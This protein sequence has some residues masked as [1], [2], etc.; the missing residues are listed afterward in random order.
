[1]RIRTLLLAKAIPSAIAFALI[2]SGLL[3]QGIAQPQTPPQQQRTRR[4][5]R[6]H[7]PKIEVTSPDGKLKFILLPN[8]ERLTFTLTMGAATV[9]EPSPIAMTLDGYDL[10]SGVVFGDTQ[11]YQTDETYPWYG[12]H[13][14]AVDQSNGAKIALV[15]DLSLTQYVLEVRAFNEGVAFRHVIPGEENRTRVPDEY[16]CFLIPDGSTVWYGGLADGHYETEYAS[17]PI[18]D[19]QPGEWAGPPLTLRLPHEAGYASI[20]EANLVNYSGMGLESDGHR[21]WVIGL[22][23]RQPLNWPFELRYGREEGARLGKPA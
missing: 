5:Q 7:M 10:S 9:I 8:A 18:A 16:S 2:A 17:K 11:R 6:V 21:G 14:T 1:M 23:H 13:S 15:H 4:S 12:A 20:T 19:V 22:G 3:A